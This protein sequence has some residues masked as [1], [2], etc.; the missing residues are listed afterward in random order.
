[1]LGSGTSRGE[2]NAGLESEH[3]ARLR[4]T[5]NATKLGLLVM[6]TE[7]VPAWFAQEKFTIACSID[8]LASCRFMKR[9]RG[10]GPRKPKVLLAAAT[11]LGT[12]AAV[13]SIGPGSGR[14]QTTP[15][16]H[17][18]IV[19]QENHSFDNVLGRWC[20]L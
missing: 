7:S 12:L 9:T 16:Q 10:G 11:V 2:T 13:A 18:V 5:R 14:A 1:M 4:S 3:A 8:V 17:V 15:I 6:Q 19:Y 20:Y